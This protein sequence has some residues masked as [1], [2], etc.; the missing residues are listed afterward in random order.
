MRQGSTV[1][2][3]YPAFVKASLLLVGA[4]GMDPHIYDTNTAEA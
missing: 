2:V 4:A 3:L 1:E